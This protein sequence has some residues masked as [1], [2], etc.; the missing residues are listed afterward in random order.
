MQYRI[1][2][3]LIII[4]LVLLVSL[5]AS[6]NANPDSPFFALKRVQ[7]KVFL[8]S[9]ISPKQKIEY[10]SL[11][12]DNRLQELSE[13]VRAGN[14]KFVLLSAQRY[15]ATAG[16]ITDLIISNNLKEYVEPMKTKFSNH[17]WKTLKLKLYQ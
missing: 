2:F 5:L 7:E 9:K 11:L 13:P 16:Q 4:L 10:L 17:Y 8:I 15:S 14:H 1:K 12:L 6:R 3:G